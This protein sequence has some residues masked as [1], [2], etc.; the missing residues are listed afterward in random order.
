MATDTR[1]RTHRG[2]LLAI[3]A[4][5]AVLA[6]SCY[7]TDA[8]NHEA[9]NPTTR[10]WWCM[11]TGT[12]GHHV[13][14]AYA[15]QTKGMLGWQDCKVNS[16][17]F[18]LTIAYANQWPT[19]GDAEADG[20]H[21][22]VNYVEG[23]GTH[24]GRLEGFDPLTDPSWDPDDPEFPGTSLDGNFKSWQP[25]FLMYDGNG[26]N[27]ELT[28]FAWYFKSDPTTPPAGFGGDND[29][30]HRHESLC[31]TNSNFLVTGE[32][33]SD[34]ACAGRGGTNVDLSDYWMLH[35]WIIDPWTV[36][37]DVFANHHPC[38]HAQ[39]AGGP[40]TLGD[41]DPCWDEAHTGGGHGH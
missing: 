1:P 3:L 36:Q 38:L 30:W 41:G 25:E 11:S 18:D 32:N 34:A 37:F 7:T 21:R 28:G 24:H 16:L 26:P 39:S 4:L 9:N 23:M 10:P 35:A 33:I 6:S 2:R 29:W 14:P 8:I 13:D 22:F 5:L 31:F 12:G 15:G 17:A 27:A 19:L 40:A 20:W